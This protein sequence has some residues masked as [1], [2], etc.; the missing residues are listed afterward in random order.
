MLVLSR[1][2]QQGIWIGDD[3]FITVL[4]IERGRVRLGIEAPK[5]VSV[6]R[7]ELRQQKKTEGEPVSKSNP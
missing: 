2:P 7:D 3:V 4:S 5:D 6:D 1:K